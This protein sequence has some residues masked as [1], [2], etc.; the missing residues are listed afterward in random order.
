[1]RTAI[2]TCLLLACL[3]FF[4]RAD[5]Y[6]W[7]DE[8]GGIHVSNIS[9]AGI[10][11][12]KIERIEV[13]EN[14]PASKIRNEES[15][16]AAESSPRSLRPPTGQ[17]AEENEPARESAVTSS[18]QKRGKRVFNYLIDLFAL[19]LAALFAY[20]GYRQGTLL[21]SLGV[22]RVLC[23][24]AGAYLLAG[25]VAIP[26][27]A[28]FG[29][30]RIIATAVAGIL[31]FLIITIGF[32]LLT[33]E[34]RRKR[35]MQKPAAG[36]SVLS[37]PNRIGGVILGLLCGVVTVFVLCWL[38][39]LI[40]A[41]FA[42]SKHPDISASFSNRSSQYIIE[43]A[44]YAGIGVAGGEKVNARQI[45]R[46]ISEPAGTVEDF[47]RLVSIP[48]V[49]L[50]MNSST[51][52]ADFLS[53]NYRRIRYNYDLQRIFNDK[54]AVRYLKDM[55]V[56]PEDYRSQQFQNRLAKNLARA[57]RRMQEAM[58]DPELSNTVQQLRREGLLNTGR[59]SALIL[60]TRFLKIVD[61]AL[62]PDESIP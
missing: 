50:L 28:I 51:F 31:I 60:D 49:A 42:E 35:K 18:S 61:R 34:I 29:L 37:L 3:S 7:R 9:P 4:A 14:P 10:D 48:S 13:S 52:Q 56:I 30:L 2:I 41:G 5:T 44:A 54:N 26:L 33:R 62:A 40:G 1:M 17:M 57:G 24:Y 36:R 25:L 43:E 15:R 38:Y 22:L 12:S 53:G 45:A 58:N 59:I 46:L 32:K 20:H 47:R 55:A 21:M 19:A 27:H 11:K 16:G 6:R 39:N 8:K 23:A